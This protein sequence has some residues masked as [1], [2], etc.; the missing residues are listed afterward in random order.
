MTGLDIALPMRACTK[1]KTMYSPR[2][3]SAVLRMT[4]CS[5]LCESAHMGFSLEALL[6]NDPVRSC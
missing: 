6:Q 5:F 4:Y 2:K 1:C 3:S